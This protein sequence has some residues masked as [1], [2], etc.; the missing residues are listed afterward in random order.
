MQRQQPR[1]RTKLEVEEEKK[2]EPSRKQQQL[3]KL[4]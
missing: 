2:L 3:L 1:Q 4:L